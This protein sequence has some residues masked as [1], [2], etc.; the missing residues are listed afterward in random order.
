MRTATNRVLRACEISPLLPTSLITD[1]QQAVIS[2]E[3]YCG[4]LLA[5]VSGC[6]RAVSDIFQSYCHRLAVIGQM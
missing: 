3:F 6:G 2:V 1:L 5:A 4:L